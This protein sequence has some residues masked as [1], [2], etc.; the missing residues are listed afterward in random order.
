MPSILPGYGYDIFISYRHKDNKGEYWVTEFVKVLKAELETTFKDDVSIYFDANP[1][2]GLLETHDVDKSLEGKLKCLVFIPVLSQTYCDI[3]SYAWNNEFCAFNKLAGEDTFGRDIKVRS[4]NIA[5]RVL[6]VAIHDLDPE[7]RDLIEDVL[8]TK[9]R[10]IDFI[11]RSPGVNRA[12]RRDDKREENSNR[13]F[14]RDQINKVANAIKEIINGMKYPDRAS[15]TSYQDDEQDEEIKPVASTIKAKEGKEKELQEKSVAVLPFVSLNPDVSQE[16]FA[17]GITENILIQLASLRNLRVISRTSIMRYKKTTKSAPEIASEL[18]V[19]YILEGS[20]QTH[21][22]KV[23]VN[24]QLIDAQKD[25]HVWAKAFVESLDDIFT[26]QGIVAEAVAGQLQSALNPKENEKLKEIPTTSPEAFDL[27]LKGRHAFNQW[28][29]E[30]Y[31]AASEYFKRALEKD[32]E[33]KQAYSYLASSYSARM[34]WNGDLS[35]AEALSNINLYLNEAW[36]RG[37]TD[38]DFLTKAF[39]EFFINKDFEAADK[40][41]KKAIELGPNNATV[42]Y[43]YSYLKGMMGKHKEALSW[44]EKGKAI[45]PNSVAYFNYYGICLYLLEKYEEAIAVFEEALKLFPQVLRFYDHLGRVYLTMGNFEQTIRT[46]NAG[47]RF[48][49]VRP[50]S[51]L[52]YLAMA[53]LNLQQETRAQELLQELIQRSEMNEKGVNIYIAHIYTAWNN[54]AEAIVWIKK[55][56][57]T[58]DIDLIWRKVDPLLLRLRSGGAKVSSTPDFENAEQS[59]LLKLKQELPVDLPYHNIDHTRDV[60]QAAVDIARHEKISPQDIQLIRIAAL[61]HDSGFILSLKNHE[62]NGCVIARDILPSFGF[63]KTQIDIICGMIMATKIPQT[64][65]TPSEKVICDADLDYLGRDDFYSVGSRLF[66]EMKVRGIV[67]SEREW[68]LV[69]KTFLETHRYHTP[70]ARQHRE[71]RKQEYLQEIIAK[72]RR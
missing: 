3:K 53:H 18:N 7:D 11:F 67:E 27:F 60:V 32:P 16:Y 33:F 38:N 58:N 49:N 51:M 63:D 56:E 21:S 44:I 36:K 40:L 25:H 72:F 68:N 48:A 61:L 5:S 55:A 57:G 37:A 17:D 46:L 24:V 13:L 64:P 9:V 47:L 19:K 4:G 26:I 22:N 41:L 31:R 39:V 70:Y 6:P 52:A 66:E 23:R 45:E 34:S 30:G 8:Q 29:V 1:R 20:V 35:P 62:E 43:T 65:H 42:F 12:L 14:Y 10:S 2:D 69:Q 59:I 50:P 71:S 54:I 28:G 15:D